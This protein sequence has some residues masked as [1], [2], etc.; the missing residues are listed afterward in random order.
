MWRLCNNC[1]SLVKQC[2][3]CGFIVWRSN[4]Y[5]I[6]GIYTPAFEYLWALICTQQLC[7]Y[8]VLI[9][10]S[11]PACLCKTH[12][13]SCIAID[14]GEKLNSHLSLRLENLYGFWCREGRALEDK[15]EVE[16]DREILL[17]TVYIATK[18][19]KMPQAFSHEQQL[20]F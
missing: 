19:K 4:R 16:G 7:L 3:D 10:C 12:T 8:G 20:H 11:V 13:D 6:T 9:L 5:F 17:Y 1:D 15:R 14:P 18:L 2:V